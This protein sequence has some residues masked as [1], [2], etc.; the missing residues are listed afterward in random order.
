MRSRLLARG[1]LLRLSPLP[2][3]LLVGA[4]GA[5]PVSALDLPADAARLLPPD[6]TLLLV[7]S[8]LDEAEQTWQ[9]LQRLSGEEEAPPAAPDERHP[10]SPRDRVAAL[11]PDLMPYADGSRPVAIAIRLGAGRPGS[12]Y[13]LTLALPVQGTPPADRAPR[14]GDYVAVSTDPGYAPADTLAALGTELPDG[15]LA[16]RLDLEAV[17]ALVRPFVELGL[18]GAAQLGVP[19]PADSS[20]PDVPALGAEQTALAREYALAVLDAPRH[21]DLALSDRDGRYRFW[22]TLTAKPGSVLDLGPQPDFAPALALSRFLSPGWALAQAT[23]LNT[24]RLSQPMRALRRRL[25]ESAADSASAELIARQL[26][27]LDAEEAMEPVRANPLAVGVSFGSEGLLVEIV[28]AQPAPEQ[29]LATAIAYAKSRAA[30]SEGLIIEEGAGEDIDGARVRDFLVKIDPTKLPIR[31][32]SP[33]DSARQ[34]SPVAAGALQAV[35]TFFLPVRAAALADVVVICGGRDHA[36]MR[37]LLDRVR[38]GGGSPPPELAATAG[39]AGPGTQSVLACDLAGLISGCLSFF[40]QTPATE[41]PPLGRAP[42]LAVGGVRDHRLDFAFEPDFA[43]LKIMADK[44]GQLSAARKKAEPQDDGRTGETKAR[45]AN[46]Y[47]DPSR[48]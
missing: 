15:V 23:A 35:A 8:S 19:A 30:S 33:P 34:L 36:A 45:G 13:T 21:L 31:W 48:R 32:T 27:T 41:M 10:K 4:L 44:L 26:A 22:G 6:A 17:C 3:A 11:A 38:G 25:Y 20:A 2:V 24:S 12:S 7:L 46:R 5:P 42:C 37:A 40:S 18:L 43:A 39:R 9:G 29:A 1:R 16:A 28:S 47:R 14:R